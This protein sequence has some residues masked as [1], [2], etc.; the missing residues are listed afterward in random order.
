MHQN[1][2]LTGGIIKLSN[3]SSEKKACIIKKVW[4]TELLIYFQSSKK[5]GL[6]RRGLH[7]GAPSP[8]SAD[9]CKTQTNLNPLLTPGVP[10]FG[11]I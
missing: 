6:I 4:I 10:Y 2:C 5:K 7:R 8:E 11:H 1:V 3:F 9:L